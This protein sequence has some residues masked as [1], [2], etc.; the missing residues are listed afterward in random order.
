MSKKV[1]RWVGSHS[2]SHSKESHSK[3]S[4]GEGSHSKSH[5][6]ESHSKGSHTWKKV[7]VTAEKRS[8]GCANDVAPIEM[9]SEQ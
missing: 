2:K 1:G 4:H 9:T 5:S 7:R 8:M 6:K 3:G